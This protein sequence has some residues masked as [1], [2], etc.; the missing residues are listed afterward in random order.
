MI[1]SIIAAV[2]ENGG[3]G[4]GGH[5]PWRISTDLQLFKQTTMG[6]HL[7]VGR[8]TYESISKPLPGRQ[9]VVI[10]RQE[11]YST[12]GTTVVHSLQE[13]LDFAREEGASEAF[14]GGGAE[15]YAQALP[16][17]DR[18]YL[19]RVHAVVEADTFFPLYDEKEWVLQESRDYPTGERDEYAF[20]WELWER[21]HTRDF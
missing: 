6:H 2:G 16:I 20:T 8:K 3:I 1:V 4:L 7:I 13:A 21:G 12:P 15:I 18:M 10:T 9:M 19:S 17:T 11:G 14:I 5:L